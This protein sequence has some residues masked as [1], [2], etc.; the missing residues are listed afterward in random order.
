M[1]LRAFFEGMR[2]RRPVNLVIASCKVL[3]SLSAI[4]VR[5]PDE[6][7]LHQASGGSGL[8]GTVAEVDI[9]STVLMLAM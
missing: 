1:T 8:L 9:S 3:L 6:W 2:C 5:S 4:R 7:V